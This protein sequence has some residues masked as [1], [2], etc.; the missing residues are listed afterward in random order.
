MRV[1]NKI[2]YGAKKTN[3]KQIILPEPSRYRWHD[4]LFDVF[5]VAAMIILGTLWILTMTFIFTQ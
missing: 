3:R 2:I 5:S 1:S 4:L